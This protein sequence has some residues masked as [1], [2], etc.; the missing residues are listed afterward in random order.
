MEVTWIDYVFIPSDDPEVES[1]FSA[2]ERRGEVV[3]SHRTFWGKHMLTV[4]LD[5]GKLVEVEADRVRVLQRLLA[6]GRRG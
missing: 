3:S 2:T 6:R 1:V 4:A 5:N